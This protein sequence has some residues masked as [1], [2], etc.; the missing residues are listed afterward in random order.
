[1]VKTICW[2]S[3]PRIGA[4]LENLQPRCKEVCTECVSLLHRG[5]LIGAVNQ[6]GIE[7]PW[8]ASQEHLRAEYLRSRVLFILTALF[9]LTFHHLNKKNKKNNNYFLETHSPYKQMI[10]LCSH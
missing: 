4:E 1:M 5:A 10:A 7:T 6:P 8:L 9:F 2:E 3:K